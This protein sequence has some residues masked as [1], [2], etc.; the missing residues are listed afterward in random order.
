M[1]WDQHTFEYVYGVIKIMWYFP[2]YR[3]FYEAWPTRI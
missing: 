2:P 1:I 3:L